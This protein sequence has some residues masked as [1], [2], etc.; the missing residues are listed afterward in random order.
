MLLAE[1]EE[2]VEMMKVT[3]VGDTEAAAEAAVLAEKDIAVEE[4]LLHVLAVLPFLMLLLTTT[5]F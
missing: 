1:E 5:F 2:V 3:E 4:V